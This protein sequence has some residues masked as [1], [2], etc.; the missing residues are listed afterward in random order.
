MDLQIQLR[1]K[2]TFALIAALGVVSAVAA[3]EPAWRKAPAKEWVQLFNGRNLEGWTPKITGYPL[4]ENYG[5]T[6]RVV[7]G[8]LTV[9]YDRYDNFGNR[10]GHLFWRDRLADYV[11]AVE[12]RFTGEQAPGGPGWAWRNSGIMLHGQ[13]PKTIGKDQ[14]FPISIEVQLLGGRETGER[15]TANLCTPGTNVVMSGKLVTTHCINSKSKTYRGDQWVRAEVEVIGGK[16]IRHFVDGVL[17]LEYE[18]PQVGGG[19]V[20]NFQ[21]E[22]KP[23]G[24]ILTGGS[25]SL[26][27]ESHPVQFRKV[28][29]LSLAG[30]GS[31]KSPAWCR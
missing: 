13:D 30:C 16:T 7:D 15:S 5:N 14:D 31:A 12:Y 9:S 27:S 8:Y 21:P 4:G 6:F 24:Q 10:F 26:Q 23:D 1:I 20:N 3:Q 28:E 29:M 22:A 19:S 25:I 18:Q 17:V 11:V 2:R